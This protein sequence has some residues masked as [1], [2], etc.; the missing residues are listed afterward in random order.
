MIRKRK[1][2][3]QI[4]EESSVSN[5][6]EKKKKPLPWPLQVLYGILAL[7][8]LAFVFAYPYHYLKDVIAF[9]QPSSPDNGSSV[10]SEAKVGTYCTIKS[11][12]L[13]G[14]PVY[15]KPG[16]M[17]QKAFV[18]EGKCLQFLSNELASG[19]EWAHV[20]YCG[21]DAWMPMEQIRFISEEERYIRVGS[22]VYTN[23]LTEL[24]VK[25]YAEADVKSEEV[26]DSIIYGSEYE[27]L[28]LDHG[29]GQVKDE[30]RSFWI[31]MYHMGSYEAKRWKV[32]TLSE[33]GQINLR[34]DPD[35]DSHSLGKIP[36]DTEFT[37]ET[38]ENGWGRVEYDGL[39]GWVM[40]HYMIP[41]DE[42]R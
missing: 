8:C 4:T 12:S 27:I 2:K 34:E 20:D 17:V 5:K 16:D 6:E 33:S 23:S 3:K 7:V 39:T 29:W 22:I 26:E 24:G 28:A 37:I 42:S 14:I 41:I 18:P 31:N 38:F 19:K 13:D 36:E 15:D 30:G 10:K 35:Q 32:Q 11:N 1:Y 9:A 21:I 25:G 40:L